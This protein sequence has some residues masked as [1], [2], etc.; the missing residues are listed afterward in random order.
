MP[1]QLGRWAAGRG[2]PSSG[3]P[4]SRRT[5][6]ELPCHKVPPLNPLPNR[7]N[8]TF[9][10]TQ[11][12]G[13]STHTCERSRKGSPLPHAL[14]ACTQHPTAHLLRTPSNPRS[15]AVRSKVTGTSVPG[16]SGAQPWKAAYGAGG[17]TILWDSGA[18]GGS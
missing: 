16:Y 6:A 4:W 8:A 11:G 13:A 9:G 10:Y 17:P 14:L 12:A 2:C 3:G 7:Y 5:A 15:L 1:A 18:Y